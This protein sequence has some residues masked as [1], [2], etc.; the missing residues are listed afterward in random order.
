MRSLSI[1]PIVVVAALSAAGCTAEE[2]APPPARLSSPPT[3]ITW[4]TAR[5]A[6]VEDLVRLAFFP[7]GE[8]LV[9]VSRPGPPLPL[10]DSDIPPSRL[11]FATRAHHAGDYGLCQATV[12]VVPVNHASEDPQ[13]SIE[14]FPVY[15]VVGNTGR[16][17]APE[18]TDAYERRL[19]S[20]CAKA[21]RVLDSDEPGHYTRGRFFFADVDEPWQL[22]YATHALQMAIA[23]ARQNP[24][25]VTCMTYG[26][27]L[28][29]ECARPARHLSTFDMAMLTKVVMRPCISRP[30]WQCVEANFSSGWVVNLEA[31]VPEMHSGTDVGALDKVTIRF[32]LILH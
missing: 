10:K 19:E 2:P 16:D 13:N 6:P 5:S 15:K 18:W 20:L 30:G 4:D 7:V 23:Q 31:H 12:V 8:D 3:E 21:G 32:E 26:E 1:L 25:S 24:G 17:A 9:E 22:R 11:H 28:E 29:P 27:R 14:A